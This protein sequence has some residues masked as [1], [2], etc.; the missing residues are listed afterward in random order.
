MGSGHEGIWQALE[1]W[2]ESSPSTLLG[3]QSR[4]GERA[5]GAQ[6][7][8]CT[9]SPD[10]WVN[11]DSLFDFPACASGATS[12][13]WIQPQPLMGSMQEGHGKQII[14]KVLE[15]SLV[16]IGDFSN[17]QLLVILIILFTL[18]TPD[19]LMEFHVLKLKPSFLTPMCPVMLL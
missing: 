2:P 11:V 13:E 8:S 5:S 10:G 1:E 7:S 4:G 18:Y 15:I 3:R 12:A 17:S 14:Y 6:L 19:M 16:V 9:P